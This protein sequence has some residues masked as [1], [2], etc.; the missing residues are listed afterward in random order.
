MDPAAILRFSGH[1]IHTE[2]V[3]FNS[4]ITHLLGLI[5]L[6]PNPSPLVERGKTGGENLPSVFRTLTCSLKQTKYLVQETNDLL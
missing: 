4:R 2:G 3:K 5:Y 6:S 1:A